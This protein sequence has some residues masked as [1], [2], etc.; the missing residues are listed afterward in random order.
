MAS[1]PVLALIAVMIWTLQIAASFTPGALTVASSN[2]EWNQM[3][4]VL[5]FNASSVGVLEPS[6]EYFLT[7]SSLEMGQR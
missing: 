5:T 7:A 4:D 3:L 1:G 2:D 6:E